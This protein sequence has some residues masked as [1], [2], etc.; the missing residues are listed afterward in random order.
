[1]LTVMLSCMKAGPQ[2]EDLG[3]E[4][5]IDQIDTV[6]TKVAG[7]GSFDNLKVG[8]YL[9]FADTR[10]IENGDTT[11]DLGGRLIEVI[12]RQDTTDQAR[13]TL[14][15]TNAERLL[16]GTFENTVSEDALWLDKVSTGS[17]GTTGLK[18]PSPLSP[19]TAKSI[20]H[21]NGDPN[22]IPIDPSAPVQPR[23]AFYHLKESDSSIPA[24]PTI[25]ARANCSGLSPCEIPVHYIQFEIV[26]YP[27]PSN[28]DN[29]SK[30]AVDLAFSTKTPMLPVGVDIFDQLS[31][32]LVE[33][34]Q[35]TYVTVDDRSV[36]VRDCETIDDFQN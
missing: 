26:T 6:L 31:G 1:L 7:T 22:P 23:I 11:I 17:A 15:L 18:F 28:S 35:S 14:R 32:L 24:P 12:D 16:D 36:Y 30:V 13:F 8:Q 4:Y 25:A 27:D 29:Y 34:C 2:K 10:R 5:S 20:L 33:K 9:L 19:V 3:P 21:I